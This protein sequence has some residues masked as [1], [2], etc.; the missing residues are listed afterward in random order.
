MGQRKKKKSK[1]GGGSSGRGKGKSKSGAQRRNASSQSSSSFQSAQNANAPSRRSWATVARE[2]ASRDSA[3]ECTSDDEDDA[4]YASQMRSLGLEIIPMD[5]DGNCLFRALGYQLSGKRQ[6][7]ADVRHAIASG[8]KSAEEQLAPFL[9]TEE[10]SF[11][12]YAARMDTDAEWGGQIELQVAA[13]IFKCD[14]VIHQYQAQRYVISPGDIAIDEGDVDVYARRHGGRAPRVHLSYHRGNHYNAERKEGAAGSGGAATPFEI[15][16]GRAALLVPQEEC[17]TGDQVEAKSPTSASRGVLEASAGGI[18]KSKGSD[19]PEEESAW[20]VAGESSRVR[21]ERRLKK[22][23]EKKAERRRL[24]ARTQG[25][26]RRR[27]RDG[28]A[29][30]TR[31]FGALA[32]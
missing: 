27:E 8:L 15:V 4:V 11:D 23:R 7:H 2:G 9:D 5:E 16:G 17:S 10:E 20:E 19:H 3:S 29:S 6:D 14:I 31:D 13:I 21:R 30:V 26:S 18:E 32:V 22:K 25:D 28:A 24:G 1:K 12:D